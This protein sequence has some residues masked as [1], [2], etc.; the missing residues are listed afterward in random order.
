MSN[1]LRQLKYLPW[2]SLFIIAGMTFVIVTTVE[3]LLWMTYN[4]LDEGTQFTIVR[5]LAA[6]LYSPL[7]SLFTVGA[8][9]VGVGALGVFLLERLEKRVFINAG[10]LWALILCL[11]VGLIIRSYIPIPALFTDVNQL[12]LVGMILGVFWQGKRYWR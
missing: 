11:I 7:L 3:W 10:I 12:Q 1:P 2:R 9:G 4:Q 6:T 8:I 5:I